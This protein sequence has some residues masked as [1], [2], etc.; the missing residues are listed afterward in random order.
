MDTTKK[1][2]ARLADI[3]RDIAAADP[4]F[5]ENITRAWNEVLEELDKVTKAIATEGSA[6][7]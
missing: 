5:Q 4:N 6:V 1:M 3:K 2:P 7:S